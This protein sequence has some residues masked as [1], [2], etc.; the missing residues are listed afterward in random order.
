MPEQQPKDLPAV[1]ERWFAARG[2]QAR[3]HQLR[4]LGAVQRGAHALL[5]APTGA[6][7]TLAGFLPSLVELS[8]Q[9]KD[10][11]AARRGPHTLYISPLK[12]LTTDIARNLE[13]PIAQM[14]LPI[15][16]ETRTGDTPVSKRQRQKL[17]PPDIL[18]TTP[19]QISLLLS[20]KASHRIFS[21][22]RYVVLDEL[23]ELVTSK[24]GDLLAL[25]LARLQRLA[26][27][28]RRIGLSA[29]VADVTGLRAYLQPQAALDADSP[30]KLAALVEAEVGAPPHVDI[31]RSAAWI[32]FA[33]HSCRYA[34][35]D[36]YGLLKQHR[37]SLVFVNTRSQA[38]MVFQSLWQMNEDN[39]PIALHH[40]SLD[41][42]QRRKVEAAMAAGKLKAVVCTS[43]L[44]LG[45]DWGD[46]DLVIQMGAPKGASRMAQRIGRANHRMDTPSKAVI[47]PS[48]RL[49][50]LECEAAVEALRAGAQD[51]AGP[52]QGGLDVLAQ[53]VMGLACSGP[54]DM[55][56]L[57]REITEAY[58]YRFVS[59]DLL[60]RTL[61]FVA[62]GGYALKAYERFAKLRQDKN[63]HYSLRHPKLAQQYRL[64]SGT[65]V[66][67]PVLT[68]R[69]VGSSA[70]RG[71]RPLGRGGRVLGSIEEG[72]LE[73][74]TQ[75]DSFLFGG[76]ILAFEGIRENEAYAS[77]S[78][79]DAPKIP[80]YQG[81][82]FPLSSYLAA[83][84]RKI[85]AQ[86][87]AWAALP[88]QVR[89]WLQLQQEKSQLPTATG[90]LVE[91]FARGGNHFLVLYPFEGRMAHQTLGMLLT[92]RLERWG[93]QPLGFVATEYSLA[94]WAR[95]DMGA[96]I[97]AGEL[98]LANLLEPDLLGDDLDAWLAE[99]G[100]MK[101]T[102]RNC[103]VVSGLIERRFP[104]AHKSGR[105]VTMSADLIYDVLRSHEPEH[106][107][108]EAT[109]QDAARGLLDIRRLGDF[110]Q[111]I[112]G[113]ITH[114]HLP[115]VSPLAVPLILEIGKEPVYGS[116][117]EA[118][119]QDEAAMLYQEAS[120]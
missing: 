107:L 48:N 53:H 96:A 88:E 56:A 51:S 39:L 41:V 3:P 65:I 90:L 86:P 57:H 19:E 68:L 69:L 97:Q 40:G 99:S 113:N 95:Q 15:R 55:R 18:L 115:R 103:A 62:T 64:N 23:H 47:V 24:R 70:R 6:G 49:E 1:F 100:L 82:K 14:E 76:E 98:A 114:Q 35:D 102:F 120:L 79:A 89:D 59:K 31:L 116:A 104:G 109:W 117:E 29:T 22:L 101:R 77:R 118:L 36:V 30:P 105:Q 83:R 9:S 60:Q 13:M 26:P 50:V 87:D 71:K 28:S 32:P 10:E 12:A 44:D 58:S 74:L 20:D 93:L 92:R 85:V 110:L 16:V 45:L 7:K 72:F 106:L 94:I 25:A 21:Q 33:G 5:I 73:K 78:K 8:T 119:L 84:V 46:I 61:D 91:T 17:R 52:R 63:G 27:E 111:R 81:G 43:S 4:L 54:L 75:G 112:Q 2:W 108:L 80:A 42:G 38:E 67:A 34:Y 66:E 11:A 37:M